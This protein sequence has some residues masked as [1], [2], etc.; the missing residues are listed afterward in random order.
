MSDKPIYVTEPFLPP[1]EEFIPY[2]EDIWSSKQLTNNGPMHEKLEQALCEYLDVPEIALFNN[3]MSA[4]VTSLQALNIK[5]EVITTPFSFIAT[6]HALLWNNLTPVFVD[7]DPSSFNIDPSKIESAITSKTEAILAVHCYGVPCNTTAIQKIADKHGLKV[8]YDAAHAFGVQD[9]AGSVLKQ[10]DLSAIS[11]HATKIFNTFEGGAIIC[12]DKK[13]KLKINQLKNFGITNEN[14]ISHAGQNGKMSE[15]CAAFGLLQLTKIDHIL[16]SR[17][18]VYQTYVEH[19]KDIV[20]I[21]LPSNKTNNSYFPIIVEKQCKI[22]RDELHEKLKEKNIFTRK[23]FSPLISDCEL[24]T[25]IQSETP[26][27]RSAS[28]RVLCLPIYPNLARENVVKICHHIKE[29]L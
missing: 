26:H 13:T 3:G 20:G 17:R 22:T 16:N 1:L 2:L 8:I 25:H 24:Y 29:L 6:T 7:I 12:K 14:T 15:I 27:A 9:S 28:A 11:F 4:L 5:G 19:L 21:K 18:E 10:G 23:Y